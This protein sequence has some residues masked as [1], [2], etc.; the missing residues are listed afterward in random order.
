[1]NTGG[2][3]FRSELAWASNSGDSVALKRA[4]RLKPGA[5]AG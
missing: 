3:S 1:M 2:N 4:V 5:P